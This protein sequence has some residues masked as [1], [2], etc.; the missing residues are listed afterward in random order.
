MTGMAG[1]RN[2]RD[3]RA[4]ALAA[5]RITEAGVAAARQLHDEQARAYRLRQVRESR[6]ARP[7]GRRG[8]DEGVAVTGEPHR[9]R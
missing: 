1:A 6:L 4:D 5:G 2:W 3:V 9:G 8:D 7:G